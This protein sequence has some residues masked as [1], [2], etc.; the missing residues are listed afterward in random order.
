MS[1][2]SEF[3]EFGDH[4]LKERLDENVKELFNL[5]FDIAT[6]QVAN[7][8]RIKSVKRDIAR[9]RTILNERA[10]AAASAK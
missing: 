1:K 7:T 10:A 9:M 8:S 2:A 4:E 6:A 3:R 5:R